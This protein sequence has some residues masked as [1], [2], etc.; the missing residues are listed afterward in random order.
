M[1]ER[2]NDDPV[3]ATALR[4]LG[5]AYVSRWAATGGEAG[6]ISANF[7]QAASFRYR[8]STMPG[9]DYPKLG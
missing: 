8:D 9:Y 3:A 6:S 4:R 7:T 1:Q 2:G 5:V